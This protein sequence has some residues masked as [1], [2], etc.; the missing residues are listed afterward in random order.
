MNTSVKPWSI[1]RQVLWLVGALGLL[2][3]WLGLFAAFMLHAGFGPGKQISPPGLTDLFDVICCSALGTYYIVVAHR[4][5]TRRLWRAGLVIHGLLAVFLIAS[6]ALS[7]IPMLVVWAVAWIVYAGRNTFAAHPL[8]SSLSG[9][10]DCGS[11]CDG[12]FSAA[13]RSTSG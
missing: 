13:H 2:L 12:A 1:Y 3:L 4:V 11:V 5:W 10:P 6:G 7:A 9:C 8:N